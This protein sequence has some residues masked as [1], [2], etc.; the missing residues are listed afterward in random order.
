MRQTLFYIPS[1]LWGVPLFGFGVLL[2]VWAVASLVF[3]GARIRQYGFDAETADTCPSCW[4]RRGNR[5]HHS[6]GDA[7][8]RIADSRL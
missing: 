6:G 4:C 7:A 8:G 1:E 5:L 3:L 2:A